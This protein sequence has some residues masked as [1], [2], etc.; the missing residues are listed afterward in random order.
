VERYNDEQDWLNYR[1]ALTCSV[2]ASGL[3]GKE[4]KPEDF[5]PQKNITSEVQ[6]PDQ[7]LAQLKVLNALMGGKTIIPKTETPEETHGVTR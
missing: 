4:F 6:N 3:V 7:M 1:A 5:M 2:I